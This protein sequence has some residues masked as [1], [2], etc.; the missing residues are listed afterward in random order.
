MKLLILFLLCISQTANSSTIVI[1]LFSSQLVGATATVS[2][3]VVDLTDVVGHGLQL[4]TACPS[5]CTASAEY[6]YSND[7]IT[8]VQ[9]GSQDITVAA[10]GTIMDTQLN[11]YYKFLRID[12]TNITGATTISASICTKVGL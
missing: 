2:S 5:A 11:D 12:Y 10:A 4:T 9:D 8:F 3:P 6:H 7:G 1:T